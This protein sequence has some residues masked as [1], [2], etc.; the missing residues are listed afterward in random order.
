MK[1]ILEGGPLSII[2]ILSLFFAQ[3]MTA[4]TY[5]ASKGN[6][7]WTEWI[8]NV[9]FGTINNASQKEG[10][11]NFTSQTVSL[12]QGSS[13]TLTVTQGFSWAGDPSNQTQQGRAWID[14]NKNGTFEDTEIVATFS[15]SN[16]TASVVIP[17][18]ATL[19]STRMRI[20]LKTI[21]LPTACEVFDKGEVEDYTVNITGGTGGGTSN[22]SITNVTG[23][24]TALPGSQVTLA[25]TVT[26]TGT[27]PTVA[28]NLYYFIYNLF[29]APSLL[30]NSTI[31]VAPLAPNETRVVNFSLILNN[32]IYPPNATLFG[33]SDFNTYR[34]GD[35]YVYASNNV[36]AATPYPVFGEPNFKFNTAPTFP[37]A[38]ISVNL[39]PNKTSLATGE[40][41]NATYS[42]KNNSTVL[43]KEVFVNMG[44]FAN[45]GRNFYSGLYAVDSATNIAANTRIYSAG[46]ESP[47][48]GWEVLDL[49]AGETR[50]VKLNFS[51]VVRQFSPSLPATTQLAF[52][53]VNV[54]SNVVNTNTTV[55]SPIT[56]FYDVVPTNT[57]DLTL[58][59]LN[60]GVPSVQQGQNLNFNV[61]FK[62]IGA[63][64]ATGN[65]TVKSY[66]SAD[67]FL[68]V[69]DY[70]NG[71]IPTANYAAGQTVLQVAGAMNVNSTVS[72]G[73]YYLI[74][75]IDADDQITESNENNNVIVSAN[76]ITVT[77]GGTGGLPDLTAQLLDITPTAFRFSAGEA[78]RTNYDLRFR[79]NTD[80]LIP[81]TGPSNVSFSRAFKLYVSTDATISPDDVVLNYS[82]SIDSLATQLTEYGSFTQVTYALPTTLANGKYFIIGIFDFDNEIPESNENNNTTNALPFDFYQQRC[83]SSAVAPWNVWVSNVNFNTISNS[84]NQF[85][86]D[87]YGFFTK[88]YTNWI[89]KTTTVAANSS[90]PL[91]INRATSWT[92]NPALVYTRAWIDFNGDGDF[93]DAGEMVLE[94]NVPSSQNITGSVLIPSTAKAGFTTM[95]ISSKF[96]AYA[97]SCDAFDEGEVE[98]Y[99]INITG[100]GTGGGT[101]KLAITN[102]TGPASALPG[103]QVTLSVTVTNTG[104]APTVATKMYYTQRT[105]TLAPVL[106]ANEFITI[107]PLAP[108]ETRVISSTYTLKNPIYPPN[109]GYITGGNNPYSFTDYFVDATNDTYLGSPLF[110]PT[111]P[112]F[113]FNIA[114]TFPQADV[115]V[116]VVPSKTTLFRGE[117]WSA[118]YTVKNN[119]T[120]LVKQA[121]VNLGVFQNLSRNFLAT[122]FQVD[123]VGTLPVNS[124]IYSSGVEVYYYGLECL[125]LAAGESRSVKLNFSRILTYSEQGCCAGDTT[126][127]GVLQFPSINTASNFINTNT[128][129]GTPINIRVGV[130]GNPANQADLTL[131][132]LTIPTSTV[133][134]GN[135]LNFNADF[136]NI[137]TAAV[138]GNFS[139]RS[140]LSTDNVLSAN[141]YANGVIVTGNY[142]VGFSVLQVPNAMTVTNAVAAGQY[143][144]ILKIDADNQ[145]PESNELNN[146]VVSTGLITVTAPTTGGAD[147]ALTMTGDPSVYRAYTN[148]NFRISAKNNGTTAFTNV[149][150]KFT[151]PANTV[152]GGTKVASVGT[153]QDYCPGGIE[154][155]E[156]TIPTLAGGATATLDAPTFVLAPTGAITAT[157]TLLSS[158]PTDNIVANNTAS[159]TLNQ[160]T[161][162]A[163]APLVVYKPTQLIPVVIQ[164][165]NPTLTDGEITLELESLIEKTVDFGISN[166]MG[167]VVLTQQLPIEKGMNKATFDVSALPQG[168]YFIQTNVGKGR[169]VPT[170]F[171]KM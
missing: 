80:K 45:F 117:P 123:S 141:D 60:V 71:T 126:T 76:P 10:Y 116:N 110:A 63:F 53:T 57:P 106:L 4:Q 54:S 86:S 19:G 47:A 132:N 158:T 27:A 43:V 67:Q 72:A 161:T 115:S 81:R 51:G 49:A 8:S 77:T 84:S 111:D 97:A 128:T 95:R 109:A 150:I 24:A 170:K 69:N 162:P 112:A 142:A 48:Y 23:P 118:T 145:V 135:V 160:A 36:T 79:I 70:Q 113:K 32:P 46:A 147:I 15:R 9:Q 30:S 29:A 157:A 66:L 42:V 14:Y 39:V 133:Q 2:V 78:Y 20:T 131:T 11:G 114:P 13:N 137:G 104:T 25:V 149:K 146:V 140:Y 166:A 31:T 88:G 136:K 44:N 143:Y 165:L 134:Q 85:R 144:L 40:T 7:P 33:N 75:K 154:C 73:S 127:A 148:N 102:V 92:T 50:T 171:I 129:V 124:K 167:Q 152:G 91:S 169:N 5:C 103:S 64:P 122:Y 28:T 34:F 38:N 83:Y 18:T 93:L 17:A 121:F 3:N 21:G 56:I 153:F 156:W 100:G 99:G 82:R 59:N 74:L 120:T 68:S 52:P 159:V 35:Y 107:A 94:G 58:A 22:L 155:S 119:S 164:K 61:D 96:T 37:Q 26:N 101:P 130:V 1:K 138:P 6:T 163:V 62:N 125:D 65:F 105:A 139:V 89:D 87:V 90:Y 41:W 55:G 12:A 98:D 151:R 168:L 16:T 108:N